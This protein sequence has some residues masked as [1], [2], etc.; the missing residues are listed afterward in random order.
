MQKYNFQKYQKTY[1][2]N[3]EIQI[4]EIPKYKLQNTEVYIT[5]TTIK[6]TDVQIT[7]TQIQKKKQV[8]KYKLQ[9]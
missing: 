6:K 7:E 9:E 4:T 8:H 1:W 3:P 2:R 5:T